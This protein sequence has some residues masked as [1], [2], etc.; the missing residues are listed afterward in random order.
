MPFSGNRILARIFPCCRNTSEQLPKNDEE[1]KQPEETFG[2]PKRQM[3]SKQLADNY[4]PSWQREQQTTEQK[5]GLRRR[6]PEIGSPPQRQSGR[7]KND[8]IVEPS[9]NNMLFFGHAPSPDQTQ[10]DDSNSNNNSN[11]SRSEKTEPSV[12]NMFFFSHAP[13]PDQIQIDNNDN[14][15]SSRRDKTEPSVNNM[16]FFGHAPS[17][18][19]TQIDNDK[20]NN[21]GR[22]D[23][24]KPSVNNMFHFGD[25][26]SSPDRQR[27]NGKTKPSENDMIYFGDGLSSGRQAMRSYNWNKNNQKPTGKPSGLRAASHATTPA[28]VLAG[29]PGTARNQNKFGLVPTPGGVAA[30]GRDVIGYNQTAMSNAFC[31]ASINSSE[32]YGGSLGLSFPGN[33]NLGAKGPAT[34]GAFSYD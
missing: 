28:P 6:A 33:G 19:Q 5:T 2:P 26:S 17:P 1:Q 10:I 7:P 4:V 12:N 15:N 25:L 22:N 18:A 16:L 30:D 24:T 14:K 21:S 13:S 27:E 31:M 3:T 20:N 29:P 8:Q 11:S 34:G 9:E 23:I 32:T